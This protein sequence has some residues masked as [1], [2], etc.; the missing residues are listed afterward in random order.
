MSNFLDFKM[1]FVVSLNGLLSL[2]Y[3]L[4]FILSIIFVMLIEYRIIKSHNFER[5]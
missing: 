5:K 2:D 3:Y 4:V 1:E